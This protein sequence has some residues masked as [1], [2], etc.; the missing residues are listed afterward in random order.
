MTT[1]KENKTI[2]YSE[3][4]KLYNKLAESTGISKERK[5]IAQRTFLENRQGWLIK[6]VAFEMGLS[7]SSLYRFMS[8][9]DALTNK[10]AD[11]LQLLFM[12]K[13]PQPHWKTNVDLTKTEKRQDHEGL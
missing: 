2:T 1:H 7:V 3:I 6:D 12:T 5:L 11:K 9:T 4:D 10:E 13:E 8:D